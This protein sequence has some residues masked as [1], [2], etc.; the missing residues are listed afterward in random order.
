MFI[1]EHPLPNERFIYIITLDKT[2]SVENYTEKDITIKGTITE[3]KNWQKVLIE[4]DEI[5]SEK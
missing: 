2:K 3:E 1:I 4:I 5:A